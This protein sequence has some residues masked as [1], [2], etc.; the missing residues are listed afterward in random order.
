MDKTDQKQIE[1][2]KKLLISGELFNDLIAKGFYCSGLP[3][4]C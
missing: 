2:T 4:P 3:I 1:H